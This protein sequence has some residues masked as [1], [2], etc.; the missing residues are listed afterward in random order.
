MPASVAQPGTRPLVGLLYNPATPDLLARAPGLI[1]YL[2]VMPDRLLF[3][4]G[5]DASVPHFHCTSGVVDAFRHHAHGR[6]VS[7]HGIGLSLSSA[8]PLDEK[9]ISEIA[10]LSAE[11]QGFS[12]FS[13]HLSVC[14][15]GQC[16][17]CPGWPRTTARVRQRKFCYREC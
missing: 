16:P 5:P 9:F 8:I 13:E 11:L 1:E 7:G 3:D 17:Q 14:P 6:L 12:W 15:Q 2:A 10:M 4:F